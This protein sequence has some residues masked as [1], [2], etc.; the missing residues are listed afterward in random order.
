[1]DEDW[2]RVRA[3]RV[4]THARIRAKLLPNQTGLH[5]PP[6]HIVL[7]IVSVPFLLHRTL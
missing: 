3:A 1:M 2:L 7:F 6:P 5:P 4:P